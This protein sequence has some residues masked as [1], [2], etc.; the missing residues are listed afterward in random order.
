MSNKQIF[1]MLPREVENY[2]YQFNPD[3]R[4]LMKPV[5]L[6]ILSFKMYNAHFPRRICMH[7]MKPVRKINYRAHHMDCCS[8]SCYD[9][10]EWKYG[11]MYYHHPYIEE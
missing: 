10:I 6:S 7:C 1:Y 3:H 11:N 8:I 9:K 5:L 4:E 2:I